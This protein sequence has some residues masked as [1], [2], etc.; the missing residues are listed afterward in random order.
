MVKVQKSIFVLGFGCVLGLS[1]GPAVG[2][3]EWNPVR[4]HGVEIGPE[5]SRLIVGFKARSDNGVIKTVE[6]HSRTQ[7]VKITQARTSAADVQ[8]LLQRSGVAAAGSRQ[9][10]P[11]MHVVFLPKT[12]YGADVT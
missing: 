10:T 7:S 12:L 2:A 8:T 1:L 4:A 11:S 3:Q 6:R 9:I 5:P